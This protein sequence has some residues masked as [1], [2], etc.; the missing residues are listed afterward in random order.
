MKP[1]HLNK[2]PGQ[3]PGFRRLRHA[4]RLLNF[5][6]F[7]DHVLA[8]DWIILFH[9]KFIRHGALVLVG[10]VKMSRTRR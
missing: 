8:R 4:L 3:M 7:V 5:G 6:F 9:L 1:R 10:R 2:N